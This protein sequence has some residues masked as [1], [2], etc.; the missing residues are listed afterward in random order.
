MISSCLWSYIEEDVHMKQ[1][2]QELKTGKT[3]VY[4]VP[5]PSSVRGGVLVQNGASLISAGTERMVID[6]A[7]KSLI[8]K[9]SERPDLVKQVIDKALRDG[10]F[11]TIQAVRGNLGQVVPLGYSCSGIV[12]GC[13]EGI[14][15]YQIGDR[16][17]CAG[18]GYAN[19]AEIITVP[20]NLTA[21]L[22]DQVDF[23][24]AAFVTLGAI[25]L[26]GV[27]IADVAIGERV[28][29]IGLG[30]LGQ[31]TI[32]LLQA[33][34]CGVLGIDISPSRVE[35][36]QKMGVEA[37]ACGGIEEAVRIAGGFS[38][39]HGVDAVIITAA[40]D[41]N[42]PVELA[43]E[44]AR[45][46]GRVVAVGAVKM[47]IPRRAFYQ[48]ELDFRLS[49]SYGPGRYDSQYEEKGIDYPFGYVRW[50]ERRNMEAFVA[51]LD[52][53]RIDVKP[54]ISHR[55]PI[56]NAEAAYDMIV[57]NSAPFLG[58]LLTYALGEQG[59]Q[60]RIIPLG[61]QEQD[62]GK[63]KDKGRL[64]ISFIGAGGLARS[65]LL[66]ILGRMGRVQLRAVSTQSGLTAKVV[67]KK[68]QFDLCTADN[69]GV[70][71]DDATDAV[72]IA[73]RH[74]LHASLVCQALE[75]GKDVFVEKPLAMNREELRRVC[76]VIGEKSEQLLLVGYNRRFAPMIR[77]VSQ[78]L[79]GRSEP[80]AMTYRINAGR[81]P[82]ESWVQDP[83]EGGGRIIGEVCHFIDLMCYLCG[84]L[85]ERVFAQ[86]LKP[87]KSHAHDTLDIL[88]NFPDGSI[89]HISYYSN[90][91]SSFS[92]ERLEIY[93][94]ETVAVIEDFRQLNMVEKGRRKKE[95]SRQDKG[96]RAEIQAFVDSLSS[97]KMPIP[98][99]ELAGV[100]MVTFCVHDSLLSGNPIL[101]GD[102]EDL[103]QG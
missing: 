22:P 77:K 92:K 2:V 46:R 20:L 32:Q 79:V 57:Q 17:A 65:T 56:D 43:G 81:I 30:L 94:G 74:N 18:G 69:A 36:A 28:A 50:T 64:G 9:A 60:S 72:L 97:R 80:L 10:V 38:Q 24:S 42:G 93:C 73:T 40:S 89:G 82:L 47:D 11:A 62:R 16:V 100:S 59:K 23:E 88:M 91:D 87:E 61:R 86:E 70:L 31:L 34:G 3:Q 95:K 58:V 90:G 15:E 4:E 26:Q 49:R 37:T 25:A 83:E 84:N 14:S 13:D 7:R 19:H 21:K 1:V 67:G 29:V 85:P 48:K 33:A 103:F 8:S 96:H 78:K 41:D 68:F 45:E 63:K 99:A 101:V 76:Q 75:S 51:L 39:D 54:L 52:Q 35:L 66:P 5:P 71:E 102:P 27:R 53:G 55:F 12:V 6:F 44:I 98:R